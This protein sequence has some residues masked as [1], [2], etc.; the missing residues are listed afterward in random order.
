[1]EIFEGLRKGAGFFLGSLCVLVFVVNAVLLAILLFKKSHH[2]IARC[3]KCGR[4]IECPHCQ[5]E[6]EKKSTQEKS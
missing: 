6:D 4:N 1:M 2:G 3:P 5:E